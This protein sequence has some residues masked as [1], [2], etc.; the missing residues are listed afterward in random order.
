MRKKLLS[1]LLSVAMAMTMV[2]GYPF[3][4]KAD[5][6]NTTSV[7]Y[8]SATDPRGAASIQ[9]WQDEFNT[10]DLYAGWYHFTG[11]DTNWHA[12]S[13]S[14]P[15][16]DRS[17]FNKYDDSTILYSIELWKKTDSSY[18]KIKSIDCTNDSHEL[19]FH[20]EEDSEYYVYMGG[21]PNCRTN[22]KI[23]ELASTI[24]STSS[25]IDVP[26]N[27]TFLS[28]SS[29][30]KVAIT[31]PNDVKW[32]KFTVPQEGRYKLTY[33]D[34]KNVARLDLLVSS[35]D[36][37]N[38]SSGKIAMRDGVIYHDLNKGDVCYIACT[39][40]E[41]ATSYTVSIKKVTKT[42]SYR[43]KDHTFAIRKSTKASTIAQAQAKSSIN[44]LDKYYRDSSFAKRIDHADTSDVAAFQK[45]AG[46]ITKGC[47]TDKQ[48]VDAIAKWVKQN[49]SYDTSASS[50]SDAVFL[51]RQGDCQGMGSLISDFCKALGI[52]S[53]YV[54]GWKADL[55]L[56]SMD[57][58]YHSHDRHKFAGHGWD[59]IYFDGKWHM[60]DV[61]FDNLDITDP[62]VMAK[63]GY[64]FSQVEGLYV[65]GDGV[66]P[67]LIGR[68][69]IFERTIAAAYYNGEFVTLS[70]GLICNHNNDFYLD[71]DGDIC[72]DSSE[73][74]MVG[75]WNL[76][77]DDKYFPTR[78]AV[79]EHY[80]YNKIEINRRD[81]A[82][83]DDGR[84]HP[85]SGY[86]FVDGLIEGKYIADPDSVLRNMDIDTIDGKTYYFSHDGEM[87][88][89]NMNKNDYYLFDG[90]LNI[91][92]GANINIVGANAQKYLNDPNYEFDC[93]FAEACDANGNDVDGESILKINKPNSMTALKPGYVWL[94]VSVEDKKNSRHVET[95][96]L[97]LYITDSEKQAYRFENSSNDQP[98]DDKPTV[99][100]TVKSVSLSTTS[101]TYDGKI[102]NPT[103]KAYDSDQHLIPS[104]CYTI[105]KSAGRKYVGKYKYTVTFKNGYTGKKTLYFT[106]KPKATS[107]SSVASAT[108]GF[109]VKW[110]K[111]SIQT[112]GYQ[113]R[114]GTKS[115][116]SGAKTKTI[117]NNK[118]ISKKISGLTKK[119]K[120]YVQVR[121]YKTV[122]GVKY[123]SSWSSKRS[124]TTK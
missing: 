44:Y 61:L 6:A 14:I 115:S 31:S 40:F 121:T 86:N 37:L 81:A 36:C 42:S 48:K 30:A 75:S 11:V 124:V 2:A 114:Y 8:G 67:A 49:I 99:N 85:E 91:K 60:Y 33:P 69:D 113:I 120:Y 35:G 93:S 51:T 68:D 55:T 102:K 110:K 112:S 100:K 98:S 4:P 38:Y 15:Y 23:H 117:T 101:Y 20:M 63:S 72:S 88:L 73:S 28:S 82:Y 39:S 103:I 77:L 78:T 7:K 21:V 84:P 5:N 122:S 92:T 116:M 66:D 104:S 13:F 109:T 53:A 108:K 54:S 17:D 65:V 118:T 18:Q 90:K 50:Y 3:H 57:D 76:E 22:M 52:T 83:Y 45:M 80:P 27:A 105:S 24:Y 107:I 111:L 58:L 70:G 106:I 12:V 56:W 97:N 62:A 71:Q 87:A 26:K 43:N 47:T 29:P 96:Y 9:E 119:K 95:Y 19:Y 59:M 94:R 41:G 123:Y 89:L 25:K 64:F 1:I 16:Y 34:T 46:I 74:S 32:L 79:Y 10:C